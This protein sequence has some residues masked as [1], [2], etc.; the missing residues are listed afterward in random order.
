MLHKPCGNVTIAA[1]TYHCLTSNGGRLNMEAP[2]HCGVT[3]RHG[4]NLALPEKMLKKHRSDE[5]RDKDREGCI[6]DVLTTNDVDMTSA[7]QFQ[8]S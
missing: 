4:T 5:A 6:F 7:Y 8:E 3:H 1:G 2:Y